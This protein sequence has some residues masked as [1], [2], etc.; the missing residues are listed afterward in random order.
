MNALSETGRYGMAAALG[1]GACLVALLTAETS[2]LLAP[3][4]FVRLRAGRG[5]GLLSIG[6]A[7]A[8]F[9]ALLLHDGTMTPAEDTIRFAAFLATTL[10]VAWALADVEVDRD[11]RRQEHEARL[12]VDSMPG[13]GWSTDSEGNF[14]YLNPSIFEYTGTRCEPN[15]PQDFAGAIVLHPDEQDRVVQH[16]KE[17]L[18]TGQLYESEH[19][20]R[21]FDGEYRWFRAI[22]RPCRDSHGRITGWYGVTLDID[23]RRKAEDALRKSQGELASILESIPGMVASAGPDGRH[24]FYNRRLLDFLGVEEPYDLG[25]DRWLETVHPDDR[26]PTLKASRHSV[27]T[28]EPLEV[29]Y[30][31]RRDGVY[32][33]IRGRFEPVRDEFGKI[34]RWYGLLVDVHKQKLAD[35]ALRESEQRLRLM[36]DTIPALV[37]CSSG[38]GDAVYLNKR[39]VD[40]SGLT[41]EESSQVRTR[42]IHPDD[43]AS[44]MR[45]WTDCLASGRSFRMVYRLRRADGVYRWHEGRA[46]PLRDQSGAIAQWY[47]VNVDIDD[48]LRAEQALRSMQAR[49]QRA[50]QLAGLAELSASIAHEVNQ[51]LAAVVTNSHACRR[52]LSAEPPNL[53]RARLAAERIIRDA[54]AAAEVVSRVRALFKRTDQSKVLVDVNEVVDEACDLVADE[55]SARNVQI[56]LCLGKE[57]PQVLADRVQLQQVLCNLIR[58]GLEAMDG[59]DGP[60]VLAIG[61]R[62]DEDDTVVVEV[63]DQGKGIADPESIFEPFFTTKTDGMGMGLAISRSIVEAHDGKL[64][65]AKA[66]PS[67]TVFAVVLPAQS[68][69]VL[70]EAG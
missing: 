45:T 21:R 61:T 49:F 42:L 44:N 53:Q 36:I 27:A 67:G 13:L 34:V 37:W 12:I 70:A 51:P 20:L 33:W 8:A 23:D 60:K 22:A 2:C 15:E 40:Y 69:P 57:L 3:I 62:G 29:L 39:L 38:S 63:R 14:R 66:L 56:E 48:R 47:G 24:A 52:W 9:V 64:R 35:Q 59:L 32:R 43:L 68:L 65:V 41:P 11:V 46:E 18:A 16:W 7:L 19:R 10:L 54:N 31:R 26:N 28:G 50:A 5:P 55:V 58:N 6:L 17:C 30:R 4:V 1:V 25:D